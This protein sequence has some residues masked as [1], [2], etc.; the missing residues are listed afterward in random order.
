MVGAINLKTRQDLPDAFM[1]R[2][3]RGN[4]SLRCVPV[5][6]PYHLRIRFTFTMPCVVHSTQT[7]GPHVFQ[8]IRKKN[9]MSL[10]KTLEYTGFL[11]LTSPCLALGLSTIRSMLHGPKGRYLHTVDETPGDATGR[12]TAEVI[13]SPVRVLTVYPQLVNLTP[14]N[15]LRLDKTISYTLTKKDH[16]LI[17]SHSHEPMIRILSSDRYDK[18]P[19]NYITKKSRP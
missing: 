6:S 4:G 5:Q 19:R 18:P 1:P 12:S 8:K 15:N 10:P 13:R 17:F 7:P 11:I 2:L 3:N 14:K 9:R 16:I